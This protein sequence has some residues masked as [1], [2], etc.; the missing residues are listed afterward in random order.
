MR[1]KL[2]YYLWRINVLICY[3]KH[4]WKVVY[5][6]IRM[7]SGY[8]GRMDCERCYKSKYFSGKM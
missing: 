1:E 2:D 6:R 3:I 4:D 8:S 5:T 7:D